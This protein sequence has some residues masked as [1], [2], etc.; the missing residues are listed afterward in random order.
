MSKPGNLRFRR[1]P[2]ALAGFALLAAANLR[3]GGEDLSN[4]FAL[5]TEAT[6][7][8]GGSAG[9][10]LYATPSKDVVLVK[11][12]V[13]PPGATSPVVLNALSSTFL[14]NAKIGLQDSGYAWK[15]ISGTWQIKFVGNLASGSKDSFSLNTT[16]NVSA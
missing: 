3:C 7:L 4:L 2:L 1:V 13:T 5:S 12:E 16:L 15:K 9:L 11:V 8:S 14:Q 6:T 10:K